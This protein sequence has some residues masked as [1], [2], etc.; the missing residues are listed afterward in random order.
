MKLFAENEK[1]QNLSVD[2]GEKNVFTRDV[3]LFKAKK[4]KKEFWQF[5]IKFVLHSFLEKR[6][7]CTH[8]FAGEVKI[9]D[10]Q[11]CRTYLSLVEALIHLTKCEKV[12][13]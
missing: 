8:E 6:V 3:T 10:L 7:S 5:N 2:R 12:T 9:V 1:C 13:I 4:K 11:I